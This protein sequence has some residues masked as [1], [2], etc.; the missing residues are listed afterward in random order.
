[1]AKLYERMASFHG[2]FM[3]DYDIAVL[4]ELVTGGVREGQGMQGWWVL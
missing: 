2:T 1:M 3:I 4:F